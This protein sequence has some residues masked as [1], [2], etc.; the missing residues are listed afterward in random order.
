MLKKIGFIASTMLGLILIAALICVGLS[1]FYPTLDNKIIPLLSGNWLIL[2]FKIHAGIIPDNPNIL[3]GI[4]LYDLIILLLFLIVCSS[5]FK[6]YYRKNRIWFIVSISLVI[7]GITVYFLTQLAGRSA[8]MAS[9]IFLS[10]PLLRV[11]QNRI[12]GLI[13]IS[14]NLLL[15]LGDFTVGTHLF[16]IAPLFLSGYIL[17]IIWLFTIS[18]I[19]S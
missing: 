2:I 1:Q 15:L 16:F 3:F 9:G 18:K 8:F 6:L 12:S 11:F 10:I 4:N 7:L 19:L 13:G 17:L 14:S 5:L